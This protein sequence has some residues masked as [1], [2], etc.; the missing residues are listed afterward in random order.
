[1]KKHIVIINNECFRDTDIPLVKLLAAQFIIDYYVILD[2]NT[3]ITKNGITSFF[4]SYKDVNVFFVNGKYRRREFRYL[5]LMMGIFWRIFRNNPICLLT[6]IKDDVYSNICLALLFKKKILYMLHDVQRHPIKRFTFSDLL[7]KMLDR[8]MLCSCR[9]F[10]LF[11]YEQYALFKD[12]YPLKKA[13]FIPKPLQNYGGSKLQKT[14]IEEECN[15]LFLGRIDFY[16]GLDILIDAF[17]R[18]PNNSQK[19]VTLSIYGTENSDNWRKRIKKK[20]E[21]YNLQIRF[22]DDSEIAD[23]FKIHHFLVLPY[24]QVTQ[25]GP[26]SIA[27]NYGLPVIASDIGIFNHLI[28]NEV[29]G[30]LFGKE[31]VDGLTKCMEKCL[32]MNLK[33]YNL[34]SQNVEK[35]KES[36]YDDNV[37]F[38]RLTELII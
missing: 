13:N 20:K 14:N 24:R 5:L 23:I 22:F 15:F 27:L 21:A 17:E 11:S 7:G 29:N 1:M 37:A 8:L 3:K 31:S 33:D 10:L 38:S 36:I 9:K 32:L 25:S 2:A 12:L 18:L 26:F 34:M 19:K 28:T 30:F 16:K 4:D 35:L 6:G